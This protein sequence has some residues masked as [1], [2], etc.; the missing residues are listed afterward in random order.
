MTPVI[1]DALAKRY[2]A[3]E[4]ACFF[5]VNEGTG[6]H[7]GRRAD[8]IAMNLFPSR[9]L[10]IHGVEVKVSRSDWLR[11]MADPTKADALIRYC[12]HWWVATTPGIVRDGELPPT[13]GLMEL[14]GNV[15]RQK[16]AA[17]LLEAMP[18]D[19]PFIAALLRSADMKSKRD[20][21]AEVERRNLR[22]RSDDE[23]TRRVKDL[24]RERAGLADVVA[25]IEAITGD[26]ISGWVDGEEIGRAV[27]MVRT[28]GVQGTYSGIASLVR[29]MRTTADK[30]ESLLIDT[31]GGEDDQ[32]S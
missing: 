30:A 6:R 7:S 31:K 4:W 20:L 1:R 32:F 22:Q 17:P 13:W 3:P 15:L 16:V 2:S 10:R 21:R 29:Q 26:K 24:T 5:E 28:L 8:A 19:R 11:E 27:R 14:S 9:G 25:K 18:M 23:V 12:D